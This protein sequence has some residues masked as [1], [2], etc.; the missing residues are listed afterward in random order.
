MATSKRVKNVGRTTAS[1]K[2]SKPRS[3]K[4]GAA[5]RRTTSNAANTTI[6][7]TASSFDGLVSEL[8]EFITESRR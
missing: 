7:R 1:A 3:G 8:R 2:V 6:A 5:T 4:T